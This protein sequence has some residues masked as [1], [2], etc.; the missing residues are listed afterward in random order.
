MT[1]FQGGCKLEKEELRLQYSGFIIFAAQIVSVAT[2]LIFTLL[3][4]RNMTQEQFGVWS[5]VFDLGSYFAMFTILFPFWAVRF[6]ARKQPGTIKTGFVANL[7][8]GLVAMAI[9]IP[10]V[11]PAT[12]AFHSQAYILIYLIAA[13]QIL[14]LYLITMLESCLRAVKP[15]AVGQ[16]L[17]V[18]EFVKVA[19]ALI[20]ILGFHQ[21]FL[22]AVLGIVLGGALQ[23]IFYVKLVWAD[24][25]EQL[26]KDYIVQWLKGSAAN[27][28]NMIGAQ[29]LNYV[30]ILL[31]LTPVGPEARA[32]YAAGATFAGV[33]GY[34]SV[35]SYALYPKLLARNCSENEVS[36][37][38]KTVFMMAIPLATIAMAMPKSLLIVLNVTYSNSSPIL[39]LQSIDML[40]M[41]VS[42]FYSTCLMGVE[43]FDE[44]GK[45]SLRKLV[46][47]KIFKVFTL[48]YIQSA[49]ALPATYLFLK[50]LT[51]N[52]PVQAASY[53]VAIIIAVHAGGF[54][55]LY[56]LGHKSTK[57][58]V[59]WKS[60]GKYV[61]AALATAA[62]IVALPTTTTLTLTFAK[63]LIA[64]GV[65]VGI[66]S[67]IDSEARILFGLILKEIKQTFKKEPKQQE[68]V[69]SSQLE[70]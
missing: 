6:A 41:M 26:H 36:L 29:I 20:L 66:L 35:L 62:V 56:I 23:A 14:N 15:Q 34:A 67:L 24:F 57:V 19:I 10:L 28:Y 42:T 43:H 3:L 63:M 33:I 69:L 53:V 51:L 65:Y 44:Q 1:E 17:L 38:F 4:T 12:S 5:N 32:D 2:G 50:T 16:G 52:N 54:V 31:F 39:I 49:I 37:S 13:V 47:S 45:I 18:E 40:V 11:F 48:P 9:Y 30:L 60:I 68:D 61:L 21:L 8:I 25:R 7:V 27:A 22:G 46:R 70:K 55:G 58:G 64:I 59:E